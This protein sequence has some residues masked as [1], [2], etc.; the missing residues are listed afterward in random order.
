MK[1]HNTNAMTNEEIDA[2]IQLCNLQNI[3]FISLEPLSYDDT[4]FVQ[5]EL[6][7]VPVHSK[8]NNTKQQ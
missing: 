4:I 6:G 8:F 3:C 2:R 5:H 7:R 1:K